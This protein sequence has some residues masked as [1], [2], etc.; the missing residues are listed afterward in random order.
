MAMAQPKPVFDTTRIAKDMALRGW[1]NRDLARESQTSPQT[2]G[3][4]MTG[5]RQT[6]KT[7]AAIARAMNKPLRRY[8]SHVE[9]A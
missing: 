4:F 5:E 8:F 1:N 9:A 2:I 7:A 6:P 3:S